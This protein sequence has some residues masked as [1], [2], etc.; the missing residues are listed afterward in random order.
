ME[1]NKKLKNRYRDSITV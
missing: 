1:S